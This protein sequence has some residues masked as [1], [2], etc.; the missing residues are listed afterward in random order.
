MEPQKVGS[1]PLGTTCG[2][3]LLSGLPSL[4]FDLLREKKVNYLWPAGPSH[5]M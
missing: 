4:G 2:S 5:Q 3:L 1:S